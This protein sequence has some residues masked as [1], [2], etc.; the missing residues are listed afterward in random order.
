MK[1]NTNTLV[2]LK[3]FMELTKQTPFLQLMAENVEGRCKVEDNFGQT[4]LQEHQFHDEAYLD[5]VQVLAT[6]FSFNCLK[7]IPLSSMVFYPKQWCKPFPKKLFSAFRTKGHSYYLGKYGKFDAFFLFEP[8]E[9]QCEGCQEETFSH[10]EKEIGNWISTGFLIKL[11]DCMPVATRQGRNL[12]V[13]KQFDGESGV[14]TNYHDHSH[15]DIPLEA[16]QSEGVQQFMEHA[17]AEH[18]KDRDVA[19]TV[20]K[21]INSHTPRVI[22]SDYGQNLNTNVYSA[23][24]TLNASFDLALVA[25]ISFSLATNLSVEGSSVVLSEEK[26]LSM[27]QNDRQRVEI[28]RKGFHSQFCNFEAKPRFRFPS[29][30]EGYSKETNAWVRSITGFHGYSDVANVLRRNAQSEPFYK[31]PI[32]GMLN[33]YP[34]ARRTLENEDLFRKAATVTNI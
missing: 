17:W 23:T 3:D 14:G 29:A 20:R 13:V 32:S 11:F 5:F 6:K 27:F 10:L 21:F 4:P 7:N 15:W 31:R 28:Y 8:K 18:G 22:F 34:N 12:V 9:D 26:I 24:Q 30:L 25:E 19:T 1:K 2:S 33:T 16:L